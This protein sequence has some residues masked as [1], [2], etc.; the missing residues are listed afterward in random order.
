MKI[1]FWSDV[2]IITRLHKY[3]A[4]VFLF[5]FLFH[6]IS[7]ILTSDLFYCIKNCCS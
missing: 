5:S 2:R 1:I 3:L 6:G 4:F 7:Y